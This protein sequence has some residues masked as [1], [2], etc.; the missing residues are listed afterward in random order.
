MSTNDIRSLRILLRN[1]IVQCNEYIK[2]YKEGKHEI[3]RITLCGIVDTIQTTFYNY[4]HRCIDTRDLL[5]DIIDLFEEDYPEITYDT[6]KSRERN[7]C[8][9]YYTLLRKWIQTYITHPCDLAIQ[10]KLFEDTKKY[11]ARTHSKRKQVSD[12]NENK[13]IKY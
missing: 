6:R 8:S 4:T 9:I 13:R 5:H 10:T 3:L 7:I 12:S 1:T 11:I 2:L